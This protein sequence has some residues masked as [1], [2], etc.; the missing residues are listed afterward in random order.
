MKSTIKAICLLCVLFS[1]FN[2]SACSF[3]TTEPA[4]RTEAS[5]I[6]VIETRVEVKGESTTTVPSTTM[7]IENPQ[8]G[9]PPFV[10]VSD[11][12]YTRW[13]MLDFMSLASGSKLQWSLANQPASVDSAVK[14]AAEL[15]LNNGNLEDILNKL[16]L[17][18]EKLDFSGKNVDVSGNALVTF[19]ISERTVQLPYLIEKAHYQGQEAWIMAI[20]WEMKYA[21][22]GD[23]TV[24]LGHIA[25]IVFQYGSNDVL[26]AMS[27]A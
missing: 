22:Q 12:N 27:C 2:L 6:P 4:P 20:N 23:G 16:E 24:G 18:I 19:M 7:G 1:G 3:K 13:D 26:F 8:D 25:V 15:K 5:K 11:K 9:V 10:R 14:K 17:H 21:I